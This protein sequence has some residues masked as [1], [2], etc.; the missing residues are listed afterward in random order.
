MTKEEKIAIVKRFPGDV[1]ITDLDST[2][3][4]CWING[5]CFMWTQQSNGNW[6]C[7]EL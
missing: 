3:F 7:D 1:D 2:S 5:H 4:I 6:E